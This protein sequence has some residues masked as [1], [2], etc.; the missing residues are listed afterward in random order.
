MQRLS[1]LLRLSVAS[2]CCNL[3]RLCVASVLLPDTNLHSAQHAIRRSQYSIRSAF[4][5]RCSPTRF[6][7]MIKLS[8][9]LV[10][11]WYDDSTAK[12]NIIRVPNILSTEPSIDCKSLHIVK[13]LFVWKLTI[14]SKCPDW[15]PRSQISSGTIGWLRLAGSLKSQVSFAEYSLFDRDFFCKRD[16]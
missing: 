10:M 8:K 2:L 11:S 14:L 12:C 5:L 13:V 4:Q 7:N 9:Y 6:T 3:L 1:A 16:L 15:M